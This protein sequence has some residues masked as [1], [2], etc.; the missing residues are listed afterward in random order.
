[1]SKLQR[2]LPIIAVLIL[3]IPMYAKLAGIQE[4]RELFMQLDMEP[5]GRIAI[6]ILELVC[7]ALLLM[8]ATVPLGAILCLGLMGGAIVSHISVLGFDGDMAGM[9]VQAIIA[10]GLSLALIYLNRKRIPLIKDMFH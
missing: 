4:S 9:F 10:A 2:I 6:G 8:R 7:I 3:A 5:V 1:M